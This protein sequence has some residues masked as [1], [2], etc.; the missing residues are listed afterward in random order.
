MKS[1]I[2]GGILGFFGAVFFVTGLLAQQPLTS[3]S[4]QIHDAQ[5]N[6][7]LSNAVIRSQPLLH[8][9]KKQNA[10]VAD[11]RG[12]LEIPFTEPIVISISYLGYN[13]IRDTFFKPESRTYA[14]QKTF[15][16]LEDVVVTGQYLPNSTK[17]SLFEVKVL[18]QKDFR[19]RGANN[20]REALQG[21]LNV[22]MTQDAVFGSG[23]SLQGVSGEGVKIMV[24]GVPLVGRLDGKLDLSQISLA[25]I[26][27]VEIVKGPL[28]VT[29][30]TDAMGGVINLITK[31]AASEKYNVNLKAYYETVGQYNIELNGA[32]NFGKSQLL[33][34]AGRNFF[35]GFSV[36]DTSRHKDWRPKEQY[37]A[38][39][40]YTYN[41]SRF[42]VS[43]AASFFRELLIDRGN[44][45]PGTTFAFD[46][47]F[48]TYRPRATA[49]AMIPIKD[50]SQVD[51]T[52]GYTGFFRFLNNYKKDLNTLV[53]TP[54]K[55][56][57][58][59]TSVYHQFS[60]RAT[61]TVQTKS[62][63]ASF[64]FGVD[65]EQ[66]WTIQKHILNG[67][68]Q[69]GDYAAF[70]SIKWKPVAQFEV[71]PAARIS[72]NT[73]FKTPVIPSI[74]I[75][76]EL[77]KYLTLRASYGLGY[78]APSLKELYLQFKDSNH[79]LNGNADLKAEQGHNVQLA[80]DLT[81]HIK[82]HTIRWCNNGFFNLI[83]NKIDLAIT[84]A[85]TSPVTYQYFNLKSYQTIGAEHRLEYQWNR[86]RAAASVMYI[87][88][89]IANSKFANDKAALFSPDVNASVTYRIPKAEIGVN[90]QYKYTGKKLLYS[91]N[92][93]IS[94]GTRAPFHMLDV[95]LSRDFWKNRIQLTCGGKN[96]LNVTD[97][98]ATG[99]AA[100]GHNFNGNSTSVNWGRS[101]FVSLQFHYSR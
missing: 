58:Q 42:K 84:N 30:G 87:S 88:Y 7:F 10:Q 2:R 39:L 92:N 21:N 4:L 65:A 98:T 101:F 43:L 76:S 37:T 45:L 68:Q 80:A 50:G 47:H 81:F 38:D 51:V 41:S 66:E 57:S 69:M 99:I 71:Q 78:R 34:G 29:Y 24:D 16:N 27:K 3:C 33:A 11:S 55:D 44:L 73:K 62:K 48:L 6:Q 93:S 64:Q 1:R 13:T 54:R 60:G 25:N 82:E 18:T 20:L 36:V 61:Y 52:L 95:S 8:P 75:K 70:A 12:M 23:I 9:S 31:N 72:Y 79:D 22:D 40:K 100:V 53:E 28:S 19:E 59:D 5:T 96:L 32:C 56:E 90:I 85:Y 63:K 67:N 26:E 49:I 35:D 94:S 74:N 77:N 89:N 15:S 86:L 17:S 46:Q 14:L 97:V 83:Q 91:I